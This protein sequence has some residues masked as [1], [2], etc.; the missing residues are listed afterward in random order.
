MKLREKNKFFTVMVLPHDAAERALSLR[1]PAFLLRYLIVFLLVAVSILSISIIYSTFLSGKLVHYKTVVSGSVEKDRQIDQFAS[2]TGFIRKELQTLL[3]QNNALR[4]VLG[5]KVEKTRIVIGPENKQNLGLSGL[6]PKA[7]TITSELII[8]KKEIEEARISLAEVTKRVDYLTAR[9]AQTP[10]AWPAYGRIVSGFGWRRYPWRGMHTGIDV[11]V[12]YGTPVRSTGDGVVIFTGWR[13]GYGK[14]VE[15]S[16]GFGLSTLY[17]HNSRIRV[18][19]GQKVKKGQLLAN[20]GNTGYSTGA[21]CHYEVRRNGTPLN[22]TAFLGMSILTA[23][24]Y[25]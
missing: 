10:N 21:H 18:V 12:G 11:G 1:I 20:V 6:R 13:S 25:F 14:T 22:P 19:A 9:L 5:L 7:Q 15:V 2:D 4:K 3:D 23:S 24:R 8:T 17:A 16:H